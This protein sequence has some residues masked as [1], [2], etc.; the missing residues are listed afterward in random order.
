MSWPGN[1]STQTTEGAFGQEEWSL[2]YEVD[3]LGH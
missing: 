3:L 2:D 1:P